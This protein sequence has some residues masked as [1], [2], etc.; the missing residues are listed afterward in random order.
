M[1]AGRS[2]NFFRNSRNRI[3]E[4][5]TNIFTAGENLRCN[6]ISD[7]DSSKNSYV[8]FRQY[9]LYVSLQISAMLHSRTSQKRFHFEIDIVS[10]VRS[11]ETWGGTERNWA[12]RRTEQEYVC[13]RNALIS[14]MKFHST[15]ERVPGPLLYIDWR[16]LVPSAHAKILCHCTIRSDRPSCSYGTFT[17]ISHDSSVDIAT[18]CREILF[19]VRRFFSLLHNAQI[20]SGA[21]PVGK[22]ARTW[23]WPLT[24]I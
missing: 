14:L 3:T 8:W 16:I 10:G 22:A 21:Y 18:D 12:G 2:M 4:N 11:S 5:N 9:L 6:K 13:Q 20:G 7:V 17:T 15:R 19:R 23:R 1:K 24:S